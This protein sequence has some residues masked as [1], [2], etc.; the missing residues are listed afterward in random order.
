MVIV[1]DRWWPSVVA[2]GRCHLVVF[3]QCAFSDRSWLSVGVQFSA[4][5]GQ[6]SLMFVDGRCRLITVRVGGRRWVVCCS[7]SGGCCQWSGV[8][9]WWVVDVGGLSILHF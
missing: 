8:G 6:F 4:V 9:E 2:V 3:W 1:G 7:L 5:C